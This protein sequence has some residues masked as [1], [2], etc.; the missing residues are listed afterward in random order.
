MTKQ[1]SKE[2]DEIFE[3]ISRYLG[4]LVVRTESLYIMKY[5]CYK[6]KITKKKIIS[7]NVG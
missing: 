5:S 1:Y 6:V 2:N 4:G 3:H 7:Q